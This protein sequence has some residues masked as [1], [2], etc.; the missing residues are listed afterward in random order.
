M[1]STNAS[2]SS[3]PAGGHAHRHSV[4]G[5]P[6]PVDETLIPHPDQLVGYLG[7]TSFSAVFEET[8]ES[9]AEVHGKHGS[10]GA[11]DL[12]PFCEV[13]PK[14]APDKAAEQ[15]GIRVLRSIPSKSSAYYLLKIYSNPNDGWVR[16][17]AHRSL[18]SLWQT[19]GSALEGDRD[20][21]QLAHM[22]L[23]LS[24]NSATPVD[25]GGPHDGVSG[26]ERWLSGFMGKNM[27][28]ET[29]GV[30]FT[31]WSFGTISLTENDATIECK[32]CFRSDRRRLWRQYKEA[33]RRCIE[34][35]RESPASP[36]G[37]YL[38]YKHVILETARSGDAGLSTWRFIGETAAIVTFLGL[39]AVPSSGP[40]TYSV[41]SEVRRRTFTSI[42][43][44]DKIFASFTGRPPILGR[45]YKSSQVPLDISDEVLLGE[46]PERWF[47]Y[48]DENGWNKE[49]KI[50][51][52]TISRARASLMQIRDEILEL[53]LN[54]PHTLPAE[55]SLEGLM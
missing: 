14:I 49:G 11:R 44:I 37:T 54:S 15:M 25:E 50:Y 28:W 39:H 3:T 40:G 47:L 4:P 18:D 42:F 16:L 55:T 21:Q 35:T 34:L 9:L 48:V 17:A 5:S 23:M 52:P 36:L 45:R 30:L 7:A 20:E 2:S 10:V 29:L 13:H 22:S 41:A 33:A 31:Y 53:A 32:K 43:I 24:Q 8:Q 26:G 12:H 6:D 46:P 38:S 27:R 51:A 19:F 1:I